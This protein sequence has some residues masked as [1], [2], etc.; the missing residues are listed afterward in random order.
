MPL[1]D[2]FEPFQLQNWTSKPNGLG[3]VTW[4]KTDGAQIMAGI[5]TDSS[6]EAKIAER[7][8]MKTIYTIVHR[9]ALKLENGD[10]VRRKS[11]NRLYRITSNSEDMTTPKK[12][13]EKYAQV[14]AEVVE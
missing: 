12:S 9:Q 2:F 7:N 14:T 5:S 8:G 10:I 4:E 11:D 3:G 13:H 6:T 1:S